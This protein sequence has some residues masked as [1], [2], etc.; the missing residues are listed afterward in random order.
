[1]VSCWTERKF[2]LNPSFWN[3]CSATCAVLAA[4][5]PLS[6]IMVIG[7]P[8]Y[9]PLG[10]PAAFMYF[11]ATVMSPLSLAR[12]SY[13]GPFMP[14]ACSKPGAVGARMCE[15]MSPATGPPRVSWSAL[16]SVAATTAL[17]RFS[18]SN[19]LICVFIAM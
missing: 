19:G 15:A 10:K 5:S 13:P 1:M 12:K 16:R 7:G 14:P 9:F 4:G 18:L 6:P 3:V 8:V 11:V 17:R 2:T